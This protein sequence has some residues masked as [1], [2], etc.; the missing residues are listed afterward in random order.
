MEDSVNIGLNYKQLAGA[1]RSLGCH[2]M[3]P[4]RDQLLEVT[5]ERKDDVPL[6]AGR[7]WP[8]GD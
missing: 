8:G 1:E 6:L 2:T 7:R 3:I 4:K 5:E